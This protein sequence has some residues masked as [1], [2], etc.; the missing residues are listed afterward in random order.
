MLTQDFVFAALDAEKAGNAFPIDFE[1]VWKSL[2]YASKQKGKDALESNLIENEDYFY[3]LTSKL[4]LSTTV[5]S[6]PQEKAVMSRKEFIFLSPD[7]YDHFAMAAQTPEGRAARK[8]FIAYKKA[9]FANLERQFAQPD[10]SDRVAELENLVNNFQAKV[11]ELTEQFETKESKLNTIISALET[12]VID[13]EG[14]VKYLKGARDNYYDQLQTYKAKEHVEVESTTGDTEFPREFNAVYAQIPYHTKSYLFLD[15]MLKL[16]NL[17]ENKDYVFV[18]NKTTG[19]KEA[20]NYKVIRMSEESY[21]AIM[22]WGRPKRGV[23]AT[24]ATPRELTVKRG[25]LTNHHTSKGG[26]ANTFQ[27]KPD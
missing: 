13:L 3:D 10:T 7:G 23:T 19:K 16:L 15:V 22:Q 25:F 11:T 21:Q 18:G 4:N 6:S 17:R 27:P 8:Q 26:S 1:N 12:K 5:F 2:G 20:V 14:K 24:E 9:Y